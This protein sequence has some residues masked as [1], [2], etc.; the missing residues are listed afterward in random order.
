MA[1]D[2]FM[3]I[4]H[5]DDLDKPEAERLI[6]Q[7]RCQLCQLPTK[8]EY[9]YHGTTTQMLTHIKNKH[10]HILLAE[11]ENDDDSEGEGGEH[12]ED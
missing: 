12:I 5:V 4:F 2:H 7:V 6:D 1:W 3:K 9:K 11:S 8:T 10:S